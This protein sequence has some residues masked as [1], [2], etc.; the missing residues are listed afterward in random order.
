[1]A[2][3]AASVVGAPG[4]IGLL[5]LTEAAIPVGVPGDVLMLVVG[6][7]AAA[8]AASPWAAVVG[9]Q[10]ALVVGAVAL[11]LALRGPAHGML[12]RLGPRVG[13]TEARLGRVRG[14]VEQRG[15]GGL[16]V[17]RA[18][19][20]L[21]TLTVVAASTAGLSPARALP[22]L[23]VGSTV[24]VQAHFVLGYLFGPAV[25]EVFERTLPVALGRGGLLLIVAAVVWLRRRGRG[26]GVQ[27]FEEA[28]C[29]VCM[30]VGAAG[31]RLLAARPASPPPR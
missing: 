2:E 10:A 22:A 25:L 19:P 26:G 6:E 23:V 8:G 31:D 16:A 4:A 30:V 3:R 20:G 11:F 28:G 13:M 1:M 14:L 12:V 17:G 24:F 21:R 29:P 15:A 5:A 9:L 7:R 27:A 18:T